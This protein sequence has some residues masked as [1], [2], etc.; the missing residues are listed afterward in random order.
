[1]IVRAFAA[2]IAM[3][4]SVPAAA[5]PPVV[6]ALFVGI[7]KYRWSST[8]VQDAGFKDLRGAVGDSLRFKEAVRA[9]YHLD[10]DVAKPRQCRSANPVSITLANECATRE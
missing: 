5:A 4:L 8:N 3:A 7:D 9:A 6:R 10:L 1:M 2:L